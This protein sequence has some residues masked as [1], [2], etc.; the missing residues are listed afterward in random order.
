MMRSTPIYC[1]WAAHDELGTLVKPELNE[2]LTNTLLD[3]LQVMKSK[4][5]IH[6]DYYLMDAFW[7]DPNGAYLTFKKPNWPNGYE[8][9]LHRILDL[10]MKPGLWF[11]LGGWT[12]E[13]KDTLSWHGPA[14]PCLS[15]P[16]W[17][18]FLENAIDLH[19]RDHSLGML[20]FDFTNLLCRHD[21]AETPSLAILERNCD[22]LLA[23]CRKA[24]ESNPALVIRAYNGFS[25]S[26]M[27]SSTKFYDQAY[28]IS[29]WW[30]R[31][32]D[33][34][35]SGDPRP[36]EVPS[37]TSLRD[38]VNWYQD[39][40]FRGYARSLMPLF[41]ID[42]SGGT[43]VGK[44]STILY[45]GAEGFT[46]SWILDIMRGDLAPTFSGD[47]TLLTDNDRKFMAGTLRFLRE[48]QDVFAHTRPI[49]GI[50]GRGEVYGYV[51]SN[52]DTGFATVVNPGLFPQSF[53]F[54]IP[55]QKLAG[56]FEKLIFSNDGQ[57][58]DAI[59]RS[60]GVLRGALVPGEIVRVR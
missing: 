22:S 10:G 36:S 27:M 43:L 58:H 51:S 20:K 57:A 12:L 24:R 52:E 32:F 17:A 25:L 21:D 30:L 54:L 45:L 9:A 38:S 41:T 19:I 56:G 4:Y 23:I 13:L 28:S 7:Y 1:D 55:N 42:D 18:Q 60:E 44:T 11:D 53:S 16:P 37:V 2:Q 46:D 47:L 59:R 31:W 35:Y 40:V 3:Q 39:H 5:E 33:S 14:G 48:H 49:L 15:D 6:F 26:D 50:P 34:V 8:P 29:P